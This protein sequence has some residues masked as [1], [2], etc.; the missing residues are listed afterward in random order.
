MDEEHRWDYSRVS[1]AMESMSRQFAHER[2][3]SNEIYRF[4][5]E[6]G[7]VTDERGEWYDPNELDSSDY[8]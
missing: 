7:H 8:H 4:H 6:Q 2:E 5:A 3:V 1:Q